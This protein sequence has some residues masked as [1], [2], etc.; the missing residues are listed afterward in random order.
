MKGAIMT[1]RDDSPD[2]LQDGGAPGGTVQVYD[3][4]SPNRLSGEQISRIDHLHGVAAKRLSM[5]L[6]ALLRRTVTVEVASIEE[7]N[8]ATFVGSIPSPGAA[9][10]FKAEPLEGLGVLDI[11]LKVVFTLIDR[12]LGGKGEPISELRG[13]TA[14]ERTVAGRV[15]K[16]MLQD[17]E[18][19]WT[20]VSQIRMETAGFVNGGDLIKTYAANTSTIVVELR[21]ESDNCQG[22]IRMGYPYPM[23]E[24]LLREAVRE[25]ATAGR[26]QPD[27]T[28]AQLMQVVP[29]E[30][31]ARLHR[32]M[33]RMGELANLQVGDVLVLDSDVDE[34]V[35]I[36]AQGKKVF[37]G[38]PGINRN[39]LA[40][41]I[42][43]V[44]KDGGSQ[45]DS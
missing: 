29:L 45:D 41:K 9:I 16:E 12:M 7:A 30:V 2:T 38:R 42:S 19:A 25:D 13:L 43:R 6:A 44:I 21:I 33:V 8:Y 31:S 11:D 37:E 22:T 17:L 40:I 24:P 3:F 5:S 39:K 34:E 10:T 14:I 36:L 35:E 18:H 15:T 26:K 4:T 32:S 28:V 20:S 1:E 23:F 27:A